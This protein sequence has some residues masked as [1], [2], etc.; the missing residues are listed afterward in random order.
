MATVY[1][2]QDLKH[3]RQVALK[4]LHPELAM[5]LGPERFL[6]EIRLTARLD[7]PHILPVLDSGE[8]AGQLWYTMPFV[9]GES[10]RDRLRREVQL[11]VEIA[12]N[13]TGQIASALD[14][15]HRGGVVHR[16]LK[17]ENILVADGQARVADFGIAKALEGAGEGQLTQTGLVL[18]TPAYMSPEQA[19]GG[20][21]D[22]RSDVYALGCVLYEMLAGEPP[23]TGPTPQSIALKRLTDP[24]PLVRRVREIV[25]EAV[26]R[27]L[28]RALAK[29]PA[30]RF[31][32]AG[33]FAAALSLSTA[34]PA[35]TSST[36][37]PSGS[38]RPRLT[39]RHMAVVLVLLGAG[40]A[41]GLLTLAGLRRGNAT[42]GGPKV[43]A[44]LPFENL[45]PA[46]DE[47]FAD[48]LADEVRGRLTRLPDLR[49]IARGSSEPYKGTTKR[50]QVIAEELGATYLLTGRVRW[51]KASTGVGRVRVSPEL[52]EAHTGVT[53]WQD[54]VDVALTDV[55]RVQAEIATRVASELEIALTPATQRAFARPPTRDLEAYDAYLRGLAFRRT[56]SPAL[57]QQA[58]AQFMEAIR[59]DSTFAEAWAAWAEAHGR[60]Y[61]EEPNRTDAD[62]MCHGAER[63]IALAPELPDGHA[64]SGMYQS[65]VRH[66]NPRAFQAYH[67]GLRLA[68]SSALLLARLG[69]VEMRLGRWHSARVHLDLGSRLDPRSPGRAMER[70]MLYT[71]LRRYPEA[72]AAA[73]RAVTLGPTNARVIEERAE[74]ALAKGDLAGAWEIVHEAL[75]R[76]DTTAVLARWRYP[77][78]LDS[79]QRAA[80][81][82]LSPEA[83]VGRGRRS[84]IL[85]EVY[86]LQGDERRTRTYAD[87]AR[88]VLEQ[89]VRELPDEPQLHLDLGIALARLGQND[90]AVKE[91]QRATQLVPLSADA[92]LG[93]RLE[94]GLAHIY[95]LTGNL[96]PPLRVSSTC[97]ACLDCC[98]RDGSRSTR[99]MPHSSLTLVFSGSSLGLPIR[100]PCQV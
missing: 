39:R 54:A 65:W 7:H 36:T 3:D 60:Q 85:A 99:V 4:V 46:E 82:R 16:D 47:Y 35:S 84:L 34:T 1:L 58:A 37:A 53:R 43:L 44:V 93:E 70:G 100:S 40:L 12:V 42:V 78:V 31:Q 76:M 94:A 25:P 81:P 92:L 89:A 17:P 28:E 87:S 8:A 29:V 61:A 55:F 88:T 68:P 32:A 33:E 97:S 98:H 67:S 75:G 10:L 2:A 74:V 9:R 11:P 66:D 38:G 69:F 27:A 62:A 15:A 51:Q 71:R 80:L 52:V 86:A 59:R 57:M 64:V 19:S 95:I 49:V 14:Y 90:A 56:G 48:G 13:L 73:Q 41:G 6:R 23:F 5:T 79:A 20:A 96:E 26:E 83:F 22:A 30:D 63:A 91:G 72:E 77:W 50:P 45:G 18:G 21:V 24:I